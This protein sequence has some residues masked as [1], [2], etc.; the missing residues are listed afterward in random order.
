ML[1]A[2]FHLIGSLKDIL[3]TQYKNYLNPGDVEPWTPSLDY[4]IHMVW[5]VVETLAGNVT[6][7]AALIDWRF[8]EFPNAGAHILYTT[9]VE[10]M[11]LSVEPTYVANGVMDVIVKGFPAIPSDRIHEWI[12]AIGLILAALPSSY[13]SVLLDRLLLTLEELKTW[14]WNT[15]PFHLFNFKAT[16]YQLLQNKFSYMLAL[17]HSVWHHAGPGQIA[18]IPTWVREKLQTVVRSEAQ[19]LF[20]CHLVGPFLPRFNM[21]VVDLTTALYELLA[22]VDQ[23][24]PQLLYMDQICDLLYHI[25]YMFVGYSLKNEIETVVKRLRPELQMRLKFIIHRSPEETQQNAT[26]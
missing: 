7:V 25:K 1:I 23:L 14:K 13:W 22:Q 8:N 24:E 21:A 3:S 6:G 19:F 17:A 5:R 2:Y 9:C 4:Y 11:A 12:N 18:T 10:L 26:S 16:H 15:T 20:V